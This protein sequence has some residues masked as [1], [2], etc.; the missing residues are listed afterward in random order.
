MA[1]EEWVYAGLTPVSSLIVVLM[2]AITVAAVSC[3]L[4]FGAA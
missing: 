1:E 2:A 3:I 4:G